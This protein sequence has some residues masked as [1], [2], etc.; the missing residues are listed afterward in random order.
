MLGYEKID[1]QV[2]TPNQLY[3]VPHSEYSSIDSEWSYNPGLI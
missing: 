2:S 3:E 1:S